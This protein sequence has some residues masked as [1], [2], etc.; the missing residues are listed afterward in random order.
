MT[1][2][3]ARAPNRLPRVVAFHKPKGVLV[4]R[5]SEAGAPTVFSLLPEPYRG[6]WCS[7][8]LDKDSEG[9]LLLADDPWT[10]QRLLSPGLVAKRYRVTV[11]GLPPEEKLAP[12]RRGGE[13]LDGHLLRPVEVR[14]LGKAPRGGTRLDVVLHEG[15]NRQ[16]RKLLFRIGHRVQ[17]L[18]RTAVGPVELGTLAAGEA[19]ELEPDEVRELLATLGVAFGP[20][21]TP[22]PVERGAR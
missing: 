4:S 10:T 7:G 8:R 14:R 9:L 12:L 2:G 22:N 1:R 20:A 3:A 19:R 11:R 16:I 17:R 5:V 6:F 21:G 15:R 18:V 13:L